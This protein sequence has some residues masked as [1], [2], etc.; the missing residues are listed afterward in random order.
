MSSQSEQ[1][2]GELEMKRDG[3]LVKVRSEMCELTLGWL[4]SRF[5]KLIFEIK[6]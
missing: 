4:T 2:V 6:Y 3:L 5:Q 1:K